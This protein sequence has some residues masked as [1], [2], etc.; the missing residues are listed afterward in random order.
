MWGTRATLR[1][2]LEARGGTLTIRDNLI[3]SLNKKPTS[4][5]SSDEEEPPVL[6]VLMTPFYHVNYI[7]LF[8]SFLALCLHREGGHQASVRERLT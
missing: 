4:L 2:G 3:E 5:W 6:R 7:Q 8:S 1:E